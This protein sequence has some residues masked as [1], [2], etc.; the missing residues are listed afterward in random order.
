MAKFSE[1]LM[2]HVTSPRNSGVME[3]PDLTGMAAVPGSGPFV[4]VYISVRDGTVVAAKFQTYGCGPTIVSGSMLTEMIIGR[5]I[6]ECR[7]LT[8]ECMDR[9]C[10]ELRGRYTQLLWGP[11]QRGGAMSWFECSA[12]VSLAGADLPGEGC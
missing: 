9:R 8:A 7:E 2:D 6:E 5:T 12:V 3:L 4:V 10:C 1:T 11:E